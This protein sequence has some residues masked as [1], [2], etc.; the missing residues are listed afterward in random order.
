VNNIKPNYIFFYKNDIALDDIIKHAPFFY[1][2]P[3]QIKRGKNEARF[4]YEHFDL[5]C[6]K[7]K[8]LNLSMRGIKTWQI[9]IEDELYD[10]IS[11]EIIY[12]VLAPMMV[13]YE[14]LGGRIIKVNKYTS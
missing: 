5:R 11:H 12:T 1:D 8:N 2:E 7:I 10:E 3:I 14:L 9:L 4:E 6:Y 13:P